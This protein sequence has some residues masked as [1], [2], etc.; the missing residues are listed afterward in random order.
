MSRNP[1]DLVTRERGGNAADRRMLWRG[2]AKE[3]LAGRY[4]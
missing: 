4:Q 3:G 1:A 2:G